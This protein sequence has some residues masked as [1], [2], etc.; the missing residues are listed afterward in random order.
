M[1]SELPS[2]S[3]QW[4]SRLLGHL[5]DCRQHYG[6]GYPQPTLLPCGWSRLN[7][8]LI[9]ASGLCP[10]GRALENEGG[11]CARG[12]KKGKDFPLTDCRTITEDVTWVPWGYVR[13]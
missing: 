10:L 12:W 9:L 1:V 4:P 11:N 3:S 8:E 6:A 5:M 2:L 13:F 7:D